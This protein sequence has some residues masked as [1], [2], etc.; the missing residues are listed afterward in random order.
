M[1]PRRQ[2]NP[3]CAPRR[4]LVRYCVHESVG[5]W[6]ASAPG[7]P[8]HSLRWRREASLIAFDCCSDGRRECRA[9]AFVGQRLAQVRLARFRS[10]RR[11]PTRCARC[12][13]PGRIDRLIGEKRPPQTAKAPNFFAVDDCG[14]DK[15]RHRCDFTYHICSVWEY[16]RAPAVFSLL[17]KNRCGPWETSN[18]ICGAW[19]LLAS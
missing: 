10:R 2:D 17:V 9:A 19:P 14:A 6:P 11:A 12:S 18:R 1:K 13:E 4:A 7:S 8:A 15:L 3:E 5:N 16:I